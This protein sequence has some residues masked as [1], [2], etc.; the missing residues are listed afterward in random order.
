MYLFGGVQAF[1]LCFS[2]VKRYGTSFKVTACISIRSAFELNIPS[3]FRWEVCLNRKMDLYGPQINIRILSLNFM[4][5]P[6]CL[7]RIK[8]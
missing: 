2:T 5:C 4:A 7:Q 8:L 6:A 1:I 3:N